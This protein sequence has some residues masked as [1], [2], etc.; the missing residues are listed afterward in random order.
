M[1][2][3]RDRR[4][5]DFYFAFGFAA[6]ALA[7]QTLALAGE[8]TRASQSRVL[9]APTIPYIFLMI[10]ACLVVNLFGL[11]LRKSAGLSI[12]LV[13]LAGVG[14]MYLLWHAYSRQVLALLS[15]K[16]FYQLHPEAASAYR[17][18]LIGATWL[19]VTVLVMAGVLF[20]WELKALRGAKSA[21]V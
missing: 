19:N 2:S 5:L 10:E 15:S 1:G 3:L 20:V 4:T 21:R 17:L 9:V 6:L 18:D 7:L 14:G 12:S 16:P 13:G 8:F 11:W